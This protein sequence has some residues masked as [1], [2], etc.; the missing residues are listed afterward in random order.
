MS[1]KSEFETI[2][3]LGAGAFGSVFKVRRKSDQQ[4]YAMK[5]VYLPKLCDK[6]LPVLNPRIYSF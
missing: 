5:R 3:K 2:K 4:I 1:L 6:G